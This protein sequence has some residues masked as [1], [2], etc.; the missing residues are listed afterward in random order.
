MNK[1]GLSDIAGT[2]MFV[3]L[4]IIVLSVVWIGVMPLV[5]NNMNSVD[6]CM[7]LDVS[8]D[9]SQGY[10]C[11][12]ENQKII[13]AQVR[14]GNADVNVAGFKLFVVSEGNSIYFPDEA[15][16]LPNSY[17]VFY[18]NSSGISSLDQIGVSAVINN[19]NILKDCQ[20]KFVNKIQKCDAGVVDSSK[21][22]NSS[23]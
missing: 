8:V 23:L 4:T 16:A 9:D 19:G 6:G 1:R 21:V 22:L 7:G 10:T 14:V 15:Y 2:V 5:R 18:L 13:L 12:D 20:A 3:A 11:W 17:N